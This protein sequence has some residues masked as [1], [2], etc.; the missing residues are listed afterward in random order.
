MKYPEILGRWT[1][2]L[3]DKYRSAEWFESLPLDI[4]HQ[5][6]GTVKR[7]S[8]QVAA[9][10]LRDNHGC[11]NSQELRPIKKQTSSF[12]H[13]QGVIY[14]KNTFKFFWE[15]GPKSYY[16]KNNPARWAFVGYVDIGDDRIVR[17]ARHSS[18]LRSKLQLVI[19]KAVE[20]GCSRLSIGEPMLF[21]LTLTVAE[22]LREGA[23]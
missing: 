9:Q 8:K 6:Y 2:L 5:F 10:Y 3:P 7:F 18:Y 1:T 23:I 15:D 19:K 20:S 4:Q 14:T 13:V 22:D 16:L 21:N 11:D 17:T 12:G